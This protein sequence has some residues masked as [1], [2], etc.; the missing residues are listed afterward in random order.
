MN[1]AVRYVPILKGRQGELNALREAQPSTCKA[2]TPLVEIVPPAEESSD[3]AAAEKSCESAIAKLVASY[4]GYPVMVD[5]GLFDLSV[6]LPSGKSALGVL[7]DAARSSLLPAQP[8]VRLGDP[9]LALSD[10]RDAHAQDGRGLTI[11]V[12]GDDLDEDP[13][14]VEEQ[15][16]KLATELGV[17]PQSVDLLLDLGAVE[18]DVA[19]RGGARMVV[20]LLRDLPS[21]D[22]WR[23]VTVASGAFPTD[24]SQFNAW[25]MGE[26]PRFDAQ[27][28]D[29]V[30]RRPT[31]HIDYGDYAIAHPLL[32]T[33]GPFAPPPQLRYTTAERWLVLKGSRNDPRG[34]SQFQVICTIVAGHPEFVGASLGRADQRIAAGSTEGPGNGSTWRAIGTT[35]HL[36][37]VARRLTNL[38]EP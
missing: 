4:Q 35:H 30:M 23:S 3:L 26:R 9:R 10:A 31:R 34:N 21:V 13:D 29:R 8:V 27:V 7:T 2:M 37:L 32:S 38:G 16:G 5:A 25:V 17:S 28:F 19:V 20:S 11:R 14:D 6:P 18:G 22:D 33:G 36:D 15:L 1:D 12:L 24:L